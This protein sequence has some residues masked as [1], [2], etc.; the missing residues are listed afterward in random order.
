MGDI[1][2]INFNDKIPTPGDIGAADVVHTHVAADITDFNTAVLAVPGVGG[3]GGVSDGDKG[4]ITVSGGGATWTIDN[5]AVTNAKIANGA[6]A[7]LSGTNTGDQDLSTLLV[8]ASNL[9]D[10]TNAGTARTNLGLGTLATQSGTF[11]GTSSGTNTG[12]QDLSSYS[13]RAQMRALTSMRI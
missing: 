6:V 13:T 3:G 5:G 2:N 11:S 8:K 9:S 10:L 12:D 1:S 7:N 4:D